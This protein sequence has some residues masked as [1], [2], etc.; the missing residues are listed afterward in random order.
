MASFGSISF[1]ERG[2]N[3]QFFPAW[4]RASKHTVTEIPGG[5]V[6]IIQTA[7][8]SA[9][10][11]QLTIRCT[12][13]QLASL[14]GAVGAIATLTYSYGSRSAFLAQVD[15]PAEILAT[16]KYFATLHFVGR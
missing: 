2:Q 13:S 15:G 14:Y 7:G 4:S 3:G 16:S 9:D 12:G 11:L 5:N 1:S 10:R 6:S 8:L